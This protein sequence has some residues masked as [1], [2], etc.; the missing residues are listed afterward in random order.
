VVID[1]SRSDARRN[2]EKLVAAAR[3]LLATEGVDVPM[4]EVARRAGVGVGTIYR[5]FPVRED[6]IDAVLADAF[7][8]FVATAKAALEEPDPWRGFTGFV[9]Q[10]LVL[11]AGNRGVKDVIETHSHGRRRAASMRRRIRPLVAELVARAQAD[12]SLR[13]DFTPQDVS[14]LFWASDRVI[15][16]GSHVAPE[17]WRRQLAFVFD[18]LRAGSATPIAEPPLTEAQLRRVG[19]SKDAT[20]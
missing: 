13:A 11:H 18:G 15:E 17:V 14:L 9:E 10:A 20:K 8:D 1:G 2:R 12:G 19:T 16:L 4:R 3:E 5:H 6:L 7:D